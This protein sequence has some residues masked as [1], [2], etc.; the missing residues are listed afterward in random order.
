QSQS[1]DENEYDQE[2][3]SQSESDQK[4]SE[5]ES[6]QSWHG[7]E[8]NCFNLKKKVGFL[9]QS[10]KYIIA[11]YIP[12]CPKEVLTEIYTDLSKLFPEMKDSYYSY[13]LQ[14]YMKKEVDKN[15][16][17]TL[18]FHVH[19]LEIPHALLDTDR[20]KVYRLIG[21]VE[22]KQSI[23]T[24]SDIPITIDIGNNTLTISDEFSVLPTE[25]DSNGKDISLFILGT[26]WQH[27]AGWEP[28]VK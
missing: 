7:Q 3:I 23:G 5:I 10:V 28:I 11:R 27:Q 12:Q 20:K 16:T 25:K 24:F 18:L 9:N 8:T 22:E 26:R 15:P 19:D 1:E 13:H 6:Q 21:A 4:N 2:E 17:I 14:I